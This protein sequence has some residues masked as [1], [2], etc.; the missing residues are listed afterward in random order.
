MII[1]K[2]ERIT[3]PYFFKNGAVHN[4]TVNGEC[5]RAMTFSH[6]SLVM[7]MWRTFGFSKMVLHAIQPTKQLI[8][9]RK[10]LGSL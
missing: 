9:G 3:G 5:F 1:H 8:F 4:V 7:L 2:S 6:L 10:L